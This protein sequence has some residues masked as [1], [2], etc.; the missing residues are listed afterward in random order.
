MAKDQTIAQK[1]EALYNLQQINS[2]IDQIHVIKGEL[3]MEV[4]D[5]EDDLAGLEKRIAKF[6]EDIKDLET[7]ISAYA[8]QAKESENHILKYEQQQKNV[9]NNREYDAL[10]KE[11]ELQRLEIQLSE[12]KT[13][14][15]KEEIEL[16]NLSLGEAESRIDKKKEELDQKR[17]ELEKII[18]E[19]NKEEKALEEKANEARKK[20][21]ERLLEA[22]DKIRATYRNGLAIVPVERDSCG[23][24]FNKVPPQKQAEIRQKQKINLCDHCGRVL[25]YDKELAEQEAEAAEAQKEKKKRTARA[26]RSKKKEEAN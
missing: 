9:K 7:D 22:F 24:C 17:Q 13:K 14:D 21:D 3:P 15:A 25:V 20:I 4:K 2:K 6:N 18:S 12:K 1:L 5:L 8:N 11:V 26:K 19:T 16:K 10:S 23:G